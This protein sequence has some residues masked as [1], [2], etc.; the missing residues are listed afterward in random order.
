[1]LISGKTKDG[2]TC[3]IWTNILDRK[4]ASFIVRYKLYEICYEFKIL[5]ENKKSL[6]NYWNYFNKGNLDLN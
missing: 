6:K 5:V 2:N 3:R 1:M 4:D